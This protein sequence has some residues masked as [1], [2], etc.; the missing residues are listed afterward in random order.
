MTLLAISPPLR[1][2]THATPA[3]SWSTIYK[4]GLHPE[5]VRINGDV[6]FLRRLVGIGNR[7]THALLNKIRS[8]FA[9]IPQ[10]GE[11]FIDVFSANHIHHEPRLLR[12]PAQIFCT[13][14]CF[15]TKSSWFRV[16]SFKFQVSSFK[17]VPLS[18]KSC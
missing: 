18:F 9:R 17:F 6:G 5:I 2:R 8:A 1:R 16:S 4:R 14:Y 7:R 15:H 12:R 13:C 11:G 3:L 10:N